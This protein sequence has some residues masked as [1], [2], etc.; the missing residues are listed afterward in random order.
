M[1]GDAEAARVAQKAGQGC[2]ARQFMILHDIVAD[3]R[4]SAE[5]SRR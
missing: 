5:S 4:A 3:R 2:L 1:N